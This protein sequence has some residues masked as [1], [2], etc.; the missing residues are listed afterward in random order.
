QDVWRDLGEVADEIALGERRLLQ[1]RIGGPVHAVE[2]REPD[3]VRA[4]HER[5]GVLLALGLLE[6]LSYFSRCLDGSDRLGGF[7][8]SGLLSARFGPAGG[9]TPA[10]AGCRRRSSSGTS[11]PR[12]A[13]A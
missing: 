10:R 9:G 8:F 12:R 6:H 4:E 13:R 5:I 11:P 2:G 3:L 7:F 1:R